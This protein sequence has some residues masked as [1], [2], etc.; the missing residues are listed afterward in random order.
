MLMDLALLSINVTGLGL[1][2]ISTMQMIHWSVYRTFITNLSL[3]P[4]GIADR[5]TLL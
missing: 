1:L 5:N 3:R 2:L 4:T